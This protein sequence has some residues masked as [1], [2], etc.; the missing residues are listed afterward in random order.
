ME[1]PAPLQHSSIDQLLYRVLQSAP[2]AVA[3]VTFPE[4]VVVFANNK[5]LEWWHSSHAQVQGKPLQALLPQTDVAVVT[6]ALLRVAQQGVAVLLEHHPTVLGRGAR[7]QTAWVNINLEPLTNEMGVIEGILI[8]STDVSEQE[9]SRHSKAGN[10]QY[11]AGMANAMPHLVWIANSAGKV[12]YYNNQVARFKGA[13]LQPDGTWNWEGL[14]HPDDL[15]PTE[16][17]WQQAVTGGTTYEMEHRVLMQDNQYR[18]H[19]SRAVPQYNESGQVLQW[20][21]TATDIHELKHNAAII[22]QQGEAVLQTQSQLELSID[23]GNIGLWQ[24]DVASGALSWSKEQCRLYGLP[25]DGFGGTVADFNRFVLPE[26][27]ELLLNRPTVTAADPDQKYEF[28][29]RRTDGAIRWIEGRSRALFNSEG[30]LRIITGVNIDITQQK[31]AAKALRL[32]EQQL[33]MVL[34]AGQLGFWDWNIATGEA[35]F[36][37][38]WTAMLGYAPNEIAPHISSWEKLVHPDERAQVLQVLTAHLEGCTD[39]YECEYRLRHRNGSWRWILDRGRVVERDAGGRALRAVGTHTEITE[40]RQTLQALQASES[41]FRHLFNSAPVSIWIEDFSEVKQFLSTLAPA[42]RGDLNTYFAKHPEQLSAMVEGVKIKDINDATLELYQ[43]TR[44]QL[45]SGLQHFFVE[46]TTDAF[47][48]EMQV[49]ASGGGRFEMETVVRN[50]AGEHLDVLVRIDF[51]Y[52]EDYT[53]I[54]VIL[55]NITER[56]KAEVALRASESRFRTLA[57]SLPQLVWMS[58]AHGHIEFANDGWAAYSGV[59]DANEAWRQIIHPADKIPVLE[60]WAAHLRSGTSFRQELRLRNKAGEYRWHYSIAEPLRDDS[61]NIN[62]W[63]GAITDIH[64]QKTFTQQLEQEVADRTAELQR[65]NED[66]QQF[67]HVASHDLK[68]PVRKVRTFAD[69]INTE[70]GRELPPRA[71]HYLGKI[72][73]AS[74]RM[75]NMIDGMLEYARLSANELN[76][77]AVDL[78]EL[79]AQVTTDLELLVQEKEARISYDGLPVVSGTKVMLYQL[80]YN[81]LVNSLKFART[82]VQP[83]VVLHARVVDGS[84]FTDRVLPDHQQFH[85]IEINDNGIGFPQYAAQ[86]IFDTYA[87]LHNSTQYEG[88]GLGLSTCKKIAERHHGFIEAEGKEGAGATF[89]I[90]LP[91]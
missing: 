24:W 17:A 51:P 86:R 65:S 3:V 64:V 4:G 2:V 84:H 66:L 69:R 74:V 19:L 78:N 35:I 43:G 67:A 60:Q 38:C 62:R 15:E 88:T 48:A 34:D 41:R 26:D 56:K 73:T 54:E 6:E 40:H 37:G 82:S 5:Q 23:A 55:F 18:W 16:K 57:N 36:G 83:M 89:R 63:I 22:N 10:E 32:R 80:F 77:E 58:D 8:T 85:L 70:Y 13:R 31:E 68:E 47:I 39:Y 79:V 30:L 71:L 21:G 46:D 91:A 52:T 72:E 9:R 27:L 29:I 7:Q 76:K 14:L 53:D 59:A 49:V 44:E 11:L 81:L 25:P 45:M 28:R 61:G 90:A 87:R 20:Y 75:Y 42:D 33:S 1:L 50:R 12:V